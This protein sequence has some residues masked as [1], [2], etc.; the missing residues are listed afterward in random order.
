MWRAETI[1]KKSLPNLQDAA[2]S[3]YLIRIMTYNVCG[4]IYSIKFTILVYNT[5]LKLYL[6]KKA[7]IRILWN[8]DVRLRHNI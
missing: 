2:K 4:V 7:K 5:A 3:S 1:S 6:K 8:E